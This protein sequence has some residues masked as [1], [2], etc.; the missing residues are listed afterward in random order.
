[1]LERRERAAAAIRSIAQPARQANPYL[2]AIKVEPVAIGYLV[3]VRYA[4]THCYDVNRPR[5]GPTRGRARHGAGE[6]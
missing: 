4:A 5:L 2:G 6:A 3:S 1:M